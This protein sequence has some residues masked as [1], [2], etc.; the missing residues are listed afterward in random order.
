MNHAR[1]NHQ[2]QSDRLPEF[3]TAEI[4]PAYLEQEHPG[5]EQIARFMPWVVSGLF[6]LAIFI[7]AMFVTF[8]VIKAPKPDL[9]IPVSG[10][11]AESPRYSKMPTR[12]PSS[13]SERGRARTVLTPDSVLQ[14]DEPALAE[15]VG[16][17]L[18]ALL[19]HSGRP[20]TL[21]RMTPRPSASFFNVPIHSRTEQTQPVD[22]IYVL[23]RSGSMTDTFDRLRLEL[24]RSVARM[25]ETNRFHLIFFAE[26]RP[27]HGPGT[28]FLPATW[29]SN[30]RAIEFVD[31]IHPEG[32]TDPLPAMEMAFDLLAASPAGR[33]KL[34]YLLTDGEFPAP[35]RLNALLDRRNRAGAFR[36][37]TYLYGA[38]NETAERLLREIAQKNHGVYRH[39]LLDEAD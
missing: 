32:R 36:I 35:D 26:S 20:P 17:D 15:P 30:Q 10:A 3:A 34:I 8:V 22:V 4:A 14:A 23:D 31:G 29:E 18:S 21:R 19:R 16:A 37:C 38:R 11:P 9:L 2:I 5:L 24:H 33:G 39:V 13:A 7:I 28:S 1:E 25:N 12:T 27:L 6:H